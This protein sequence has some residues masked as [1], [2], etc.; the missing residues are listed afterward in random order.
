MKC[1][2]CGKET[3][4]STTT[5]AIELGGDL[6]AIEPVEPYTAAA[7]RDSIVRWINGLGLNIEAE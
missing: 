5:E 2:K 6:F 1:V 4:Q 3:D 7:S